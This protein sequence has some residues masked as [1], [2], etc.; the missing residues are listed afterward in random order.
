MFICINPHMLFFWCRLFFLMHVKYL[1][2]LAMQSVFENYISK[3]NVLKRL[4]LSR[5]LYVDDSMVFLKNVFCILKQKHQRSLLLAWIYVTSFLWLSILLWF[6]FNNQISSSAFIWLYM[7]T[8]FHFNSLNNVKSIVGMNLWTRVCTDFVMQPFSQECHLQCGHLQPSAHPV[9]HSAEEMGCS[10]H[11]PVFVYI[12]VC[13]SFRK[14][15]LGQLVTKSL[16][17]RKTGVQLCHPTI[18]TGWSWQIST[19]LWFLEKE[20]LER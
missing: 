10:S 12:C 11:F 6:C 18:W 8:Y 2:T 15:N 9:T 5:V 17:H 14:P 16:L 20:A 3:E 7:N 13:M 19:S 4:F 1:L